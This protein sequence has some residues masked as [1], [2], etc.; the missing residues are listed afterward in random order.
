MYPGG[1]QKIC[2]HCHSQQPL[3]AGQC[4]CGHI[5]RTQFANPQLAANSARS[6]VHIWV[7][8]AAILGCLSII[9][10]LLFR[11]AKPGATGRP[12]I[13]IAW[14]LSGNSGTLGKVK[15]L[16]GHRLTGV[17]ISLTLVEPDFRQGFHTG[18]SPSTYLA[19]WG[20][21][22]VG[23]TR[24]D[25]SPGQSEDIF[26]RRLSYADIPLPVEAS[27][28]DGKPLNIRQYLIKIN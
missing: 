4:H 18:E 8:V 15:N 27:D 23:P 16:S 2:P 12:D 1:P 17:Q 26:F 22:M 25:L 13:E 3:N 10:I 5:F 14:L 24:L 6:R 20:D 7:I 11:V 28:A 19:E 21:Q 9:G